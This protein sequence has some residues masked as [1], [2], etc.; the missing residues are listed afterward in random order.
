M[1]ENSLNKIQNQPYYPQQQ[2]PNAVSI[3]IY[4]PTAYSGNQPSACNPTA[5][6]GVTNP[7]ASNFYPLYSPAPA[8]QGMFYPQNYNNLINYPQPYNLSGLNA[9]P[10]NNQAN[11]IPQDNKNTL[12]KNETNSVEK[13]D[14]KKDKSKEKEIIPLTDDYIKSLENY[15]D[16]N[17]SKVR[18]SGIKSVVDRFKEDE[19]R[20]D[21]PSLIPLLNKALQD[22]S[23][24]VRFMALTALQL[25][26]TKGDDKTVEILNNLVANSKENFGEDAALAS[27]ALLKIATPDAVKTKGGN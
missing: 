16:S 3:N 22:T 9:L 19:N 23:S 8:P 11:N 7:Y 26:Y 6:S 10:Q 1:Q 12:N 4:S 24:T 21:N 13:Q 14:G 15:L 20:K 18:L 2:G 25:G 27:D 17:N 5:Q